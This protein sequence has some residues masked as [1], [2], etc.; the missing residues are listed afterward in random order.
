M[1]EYNPL[2][3]INEQSV[4]FVC[5]T[6]GQGEE[7]ENMKKFWKFLLKKSLPADSLREVNVAV[8]SLG[9]S[10][11]PKFNWV[12]KRLSKR[13]SQLGAREILPIGLCDDQHDMGI[14][15][16]YI[17]FIRDMFERLLALY[18]M[19]NGQTVAS[20]VRQ[21]K[22]NVRVLDGVK[23]ETD[24]V[25]E[26]MSMIRTCKLLENTRTTNESHFQDVR[27]IKLEKEDL[28][29]QPGD[30]ACIRPQNSKENLKKLFELL[31]E[32]NLGLYPDTVIKVT[33]V[34]SGN[35]RRIY[36]FRKG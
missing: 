9:D 35:F 28:N 5:A 34:D 21:F 26:Q 8:L 14:A 16:V 13:L 31:E 7:P 6:A 22:W 25:W 11:F 24:K 19:P 17:P 10:S 33:E 29:W 20:Q 18:P 3:L 27:F 4:L 36:L 23:P 15:A 2:E 32:H 1:D 12:G 30:V